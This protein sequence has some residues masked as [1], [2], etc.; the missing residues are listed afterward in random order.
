MKPLTTILLLA[1]LML[2]IVAV[3]YLW[4]TDFKNME[5]INLTYEDTNSSEDSN[6]TT[7]K[8]SL[9][10]NKFFKDIQQ[11]YIMKVKTIG[12]ILAGAVMIGS[13][14]ASACPF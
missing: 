12:A 8:T 9:H 2:S 4:Y 13:A 6:S 1:I 10:N 14:V 3:Y 7:M 11:I 5:K